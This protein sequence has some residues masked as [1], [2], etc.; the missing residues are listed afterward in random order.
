MDLTPDVEIF[1][2]LGGYIVS[3]DE[4]DPETKQ[5]AGRTRVCLSMDEVLSHVRRTLELA[6][7]QPDRN[8]PSLKKS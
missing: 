4:R 7:K 2:V 6:D 3:T 5:Y 1:A 8:Y